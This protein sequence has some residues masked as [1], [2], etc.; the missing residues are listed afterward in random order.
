M[1]RVLW[2]IGAGASHHLGMPLLTQFEA[3]FTELWTKFPE[4]QRDT[5]FQH[6][7]P[8]T[9]DL[10]QRNRRLNVEALLSSSSPLS[11]ADKSVIKRA[12]RRGMERRNLGRILKVY[13]KHGKLGPYSR[14]FSMM[15][16]G[17]AIV[18]F[19]YDNALET[20]LCLLTNS[21]EILNTSELDSAQQLYLQS[22]TATRRWIPDDC[23]SSL[24][25]R[26]LE[27]VPAAAFEDTSPLSCGDGS[28]SIP[29]VKIHGSVNWSLSNGLIKVGDPASN[30]AGPL[31]VY[32]EAAKPE[33]LNPPHRQLILA[34][35]TAL[36]DCDVVVIIGYSFPPS[37][38]SGHPFVSRLATVLASKRVLAVDPFPSHT[39]R[40][41]VTDTDILASR[42]EEAVEPDVSGV[43]D[44][45]REIAQRR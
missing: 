21:F 5:E 36:D 13:G 44:L 18:S 9:I 19:N 37:D 45:Q 43:S 8:Q 23:V 2:I 35:L 4:N 3:F 7:L 38:S 27:Y 16:S 14:L 11:D 29:L 32:P 20:P 31:L 6:T 26:R 24:T 10:L 30:A 40:S 25:S 39:L 28:T 33:L 1:A 22:A 17:D 34:A 41:H 42:F 15:N 12:I